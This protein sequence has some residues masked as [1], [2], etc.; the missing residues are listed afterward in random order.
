M[1]TQ[2]SKTFLSLKEKYAFPKA[3]STPSGQVMNSNIS[4]GY[5]IPLTMRSWRRI[6]FSASESFFIL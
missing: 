3:V 2:L 1:L 4:F 5:L 6:E